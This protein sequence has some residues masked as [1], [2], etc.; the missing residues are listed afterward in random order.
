MGQRSSATRHGRLRDGRR[1]RAGRSA[2]A[3]AA[4]A[5]A[6]RRRRRRC[7]ARPAGCRARADGPRPGFFSPGPSR[8]GRGRTGRL[9]RVRRARR[10]P[11]DGRPAALRDGR[12]AGGGE[13]G[14]D[15]A[16]ASAC[17]RGPGIG[18]DRRMARPRPGVRPRRGGES[19]GSARVARRADARGPRGDA[20]DGRLA[21][22]R[23]DRRPARRRP[24]RRAALRGRTGEGRRSAGPA[25]GARPAGGHAARRA[26]AG[27]LG[28]VACR[29]R[30]GGERPPAGAPTR[31][32]DPARPGRRRPAERGDHRPEPLRLARSPGRHRDP[33]C[34]RRAA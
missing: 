21:P 27:H 28:A 24:A 23:Q 17:G 14:Q 19:R 5:A 3:P 25:R 7:S 32:L 4:G 12:V 26:R 18:L 20:R 31:G 22:R 10:H 13:L 11:R 2:G 6:P 29:R 30:R 9:D 1:P 8:R 33:L 15:D 34:R 16:C